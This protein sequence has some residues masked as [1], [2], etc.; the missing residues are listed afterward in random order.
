MRR[1]DLNAI[2]QILVEAGI[3]PTAQR[4]AICQYVLTQA[5]HPTADCIKKWADRNFPT[6]SMATIYNTL[7]TLVE[8]GLL[9]AIKFPHSEKV[10]Y[11][12]NCEAHYHFLDEETGELIDIATD[13][14]EI[15]PK[16]QAEF[17]IGAIDVLLKGKRLPS[18]INR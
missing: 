3:R 10:I 15:T 4:I 16:L 7:G 9:K 12:S 13:R 6:V 2:K 17:E 5:D 14:V 1:R 18:S 11:D 8:S